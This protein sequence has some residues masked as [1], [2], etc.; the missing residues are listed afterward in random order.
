MKLSEKLKELR[1]SRN[2]SLMKLAKIINVSDAS[3]FNWENEINEPKASYICALADYFQ[4]SADELLGR[5]N[6]STGNIEIKGEILS[7]KERRLVDLY[8][9]L[10]ETQQNAAWQILDAAFPAAQRKKK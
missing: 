4:I 3:I 5:E 9:A 1:E 10:D 2:L 8:R 7:E 6:Y